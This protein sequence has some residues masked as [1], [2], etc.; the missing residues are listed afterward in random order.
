MQLQVVTAPAGVLAT[1]SVVNVINGEATPKGG[2]Y[3][4]RQTGTIAQ[5]STTG[6]G[7]GATFTLTHGPQDDQRVILTNQEF[8]TL[9]Y[10]RQIINPNVWDTL[11]Q[12]ALINLVAGNLV[13]ALRGDRA[14]GNDLIKEVNTAIDQARSIDGNEGFIVNDV[15]PDWIRTRGIA[16]D[17]MI[18]GPYSN[19]DWGGGWPSFA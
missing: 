17:G 5:S 9:S 14:L 10:C 1:V 19:F 18:T 13:M 4:A 7:V 12:T 11:F 3:F 6:V 16:F 2:S 8:A 15:T